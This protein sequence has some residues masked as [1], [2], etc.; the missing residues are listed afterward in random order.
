MKKLFDGTEVSLDTP[1]KNVG[2]LRYLLTPE[3]IAEREAEE[4]ANAAKKPLKNWQK[5]IEQ[6][7]RDMPRALEDII[8]VLTEEQKSKL[9]AQTLA[10]YNQ[11][12]TLRSQK[13]ETGD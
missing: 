13:P 3:E 8:D 1:T 9:A 12:K 4:L 10:K 11:K 6:T 2:G 5:Q 7:D